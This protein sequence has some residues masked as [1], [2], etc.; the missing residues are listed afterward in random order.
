[1]QRR[2]L[3]RLV[4]SVAIGLPA[5]A[6]AADPIDVGL[7]QSEPGSPVY[8]TYSYSNLLDGHFL[9][10][11]PE[12][13]RAATEEALG[14][15]ASYAPLYFIEEVDSGL[16]PSDDPYDADGHPVIRLGYHVMTDL[17][18]AYYPGDDGLSSDVHFAAGIPW[19]VG[20]GRWNFLETVTHELGHTLGLPHEFDDPAIMNPFYPTHRFDG[21]G[22]AFLFPS[23]IAAIQRLY[24]AGHGSVQALT[25][26]PE[27]ATWI[28]AS[29][30]LWML[31]SGRRQ[32]RRRNRA[33]SVSEE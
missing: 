30:L 19:T 20:D 4:L 25:V 32:Q 14:L 26:T 22:S 3:H 33:Q 12:E 6:A 24:G 7:Q 1:M 9:T 2:F 31:V 21:L 11:T 15:W 5:A 23:D 27:P 10:I 18:H 28:S 13:L 29:A 17:A 16:A 8:V